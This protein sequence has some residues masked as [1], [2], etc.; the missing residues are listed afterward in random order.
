MKEHSPIKNQLKT[1]MLWPLV[2]VGFMILANISVALI[3]RRAGAAMGGFTFAG[4][5]L[6]IWLL[7]IRRNQILSGLVDFAAE[8]SDVQKELL[9]EMSVPYLITDAAGRI[10]WTNRAFDEMV[11]EDHSRSNISAYFPELTA[12]YLEET[13]GDVV[14]HSEWDGHYYE[15]DMRPLRMDGAL[16]LDLNIDSRA[17]GDKM[18]AM[19]LFDETR[20]L[21]YE[22]EITNQKMVAGLIYLDN[23]DEALE[24]VEAVRRSLL[25]ALID[26]KINKFI[27]GM[28]GI[29]S[30]LEKDKYFFVIEQRYIEELQKSRFALLED[31]KTVNIGN[32]MAV[33]L[34]IGIGM[35]GESYLRN[36]EYA[37]ASMDMALGRGGDQAVVK[38]GDKIR[39]YGGKSQQVEK[40]TRVKARVK[41]HAL[42]ELMD[43]KDKILIMGHRNGDIDCIGSA[44]GIWRAAT[45]FDKR[46][47]IVLQSVNASVK[48]ILEKF[49]TSP[50]YPEDMFLTAD[51]ALDW[52]DAN[53]MLVVVDVNRPSITEAPKLL[54]RIHTI[55][56]LDHHR[57]S[58]EIVKNAT[59]S[60]V[61]PYAS[62]ACEMVAEILQYIGDGIRIKALEA[63]AMYAGIMID[64][65]NFMNQ[66][67]VR[68][69]EAAVT[70][71]SREHRLR[72]SRRKKPSKS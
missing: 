11:R 35:N 23:Y 1:Y 22:Q 37:R 34:S 26:R 69:F 27:T 44:I 5:I 16:T 71:P 70:G 10:L 38:D 3:D 61:E 15:I 62:S 25:E 39:Y 20:A 66:T 64:T 55:V 29:V 57:Q 68:T 47:R 14:A 4:V 30:K 50:D 59:L 8:S 43:T 48:P 17:A 63:D 24:S 12:E 9:E 28:N 7:S 31:V 54:D 49:K 2:M 21:V 45:S 18:F 33:T 19:F 32:D 51:Q 53:T 58:A 67:G 41:A 36:Y 13:V 46:A 6:T 65:H 56:V 40:T 72:I 42:R 52:A 60:Y